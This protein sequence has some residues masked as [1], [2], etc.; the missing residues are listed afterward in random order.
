MI[1]ILGLILFLVLPASVWTSGSG[2]RTPHQPRSARLYMKS[3][4]RSLSDDELL[5]NEV[6]SLDEAFK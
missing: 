3:L 5:M 4:P 1:L 6:V 2:S